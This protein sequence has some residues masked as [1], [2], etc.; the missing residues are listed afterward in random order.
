MLQVALPVMALLLG[1][2]ATLNA[3]VDHAK[4]LAPFV[5]SPQNIVEKML[6]AAQLKPGETVFDLGCGDGRVLVTAARQFR[7]KAVGIELSPKI[8]QMARD[9]I[10]QQ[11]LDG[12]ASVIEGNLLEVDLSKADVVTLYLLTE[13]NSRLRPNLEK[14]LKPGARVVSHDFEIK[15]WKPVRVE[16]VQA[17]RRSHKIYVY[18]R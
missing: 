14:Y 16:E 3:Q 9:I 18:V 12:D 7:A 13:S 5:P 2:S 1:G 17:H 11:K 15:G 4:S 8:A 10:K 6:E